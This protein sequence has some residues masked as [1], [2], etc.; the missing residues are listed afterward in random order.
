MKEQ[1]SFIRNIEQKLLIS[2][3][4]LKHP[5]SF[6]TRGKISIVMEH[7]LDQIKN[8]YVITKGVNK[9]FELDFDNFSSY[10]KISRLL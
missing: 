9:H 6:C 8:K 2:L 7:K 3:K 5:L 4:N 1:S 10:V